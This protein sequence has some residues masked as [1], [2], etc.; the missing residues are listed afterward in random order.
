MR[1]WT[2]VIARISAERLWC[3][4]WKV[5]CAIVLRLENW[6]NEHGYELDVRCP[7]IWY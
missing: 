6:T 1:V 5:E 7:K 4:D 3:M 2:A